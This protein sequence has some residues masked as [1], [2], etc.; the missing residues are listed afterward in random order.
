MS[1]VFEWDSEKAKS[2]IKKHGISFEEAAH[3]F[4]N[5]N[6]VS[7][8]NRF[9]DEDRWQT[10]GLVAGC[11]VVLVAHTTKFSDSNEVIRLI[12]ARK[13]TKGEKKIYEQNYL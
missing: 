2:N 6:H 13:A 3:V 12:S 9:E 1:L 11:V 4:S 5:P 8:Q 7:V 10:I